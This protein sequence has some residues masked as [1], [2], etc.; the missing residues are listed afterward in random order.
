[1]SVDTNFADLLR[2]RYLEAVSASCAAH[3]KGLGEHT[4]VADCA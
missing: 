1:M 3:R 2:F 4:I